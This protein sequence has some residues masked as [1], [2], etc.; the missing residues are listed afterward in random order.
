MKSEGFISL[1]SIVELIA[2]YICQPADVT[3]VALDNF[4]ENFEGVGENINRL[5]FGHKFPILQALGK[6]IIKNKN[7]KEV[8]DELLA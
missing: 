5:S 3:E 4:R 8:F 1:P 2:P 6:I 7:A